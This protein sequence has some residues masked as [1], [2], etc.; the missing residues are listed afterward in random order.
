[1]GWKIVRMYAIGLFLM[2]AFVVLMSIGEGPSSLSTGN[3]AG[4]ISLIGMLGV[5][6]ARAMREQE[7]RISRLEKQLEEKNGQRSF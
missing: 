2:A 3:A 6:V 5:A 7:Q 1:M 4:I